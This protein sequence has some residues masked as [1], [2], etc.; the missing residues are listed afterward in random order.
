MS[1]K[2][3]RI[4]L[5][6][7]LW[8]YSYRDLVKNRAFYEL[9]GKKFIK[10]ENNLQLVLLHYVYINLRSQYNYRGKSPNW[11]SSLIILLIKRLFGNV[12]S[13]RPEVFCKKGTLKNFAKFTGKRLC[14]S[15]FYNNIAGLSP[16]ACNFIKIEILTQVLS[17]KFCEVVK[18][19]F[20]DGTTEG[21]F[22][23]V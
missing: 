1:Q 6:I 15:L 14:W 23:N 8:K 5:S 9:C 3:W 13:S 12:S 18:N 20:F 16:E 17:C 7:N 21:C 4:Y 10:N 22:L 19:T 11:I 2:L